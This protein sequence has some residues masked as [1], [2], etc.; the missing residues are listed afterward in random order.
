LT[1][2]LAGLFFP[3]NQDVV[4]WSEKGKKWFEDEIAYQRY[5]DGTFLQFSMNYHRVVVQ[6]LTWA[7]RLSEL[8]KKELSPI[9]YHRA[10]ASLKFLRI[11]MD[12]VT[13][14]LPNYGANDGALFFKMSEA[15]YRDYRPQLKA[16]AGALGVDAQLEAATEDTGWF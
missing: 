6:L 7:V 1:L 12:D 14:W 16:L 2:Y 15:H 5:E 13:G 3:T 9:V 11:C 10:K 8:N 4:T